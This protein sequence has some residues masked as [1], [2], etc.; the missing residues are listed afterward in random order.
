M[1][2]MFHPP[3]TKCKLKYEQQNPNCE[4]ESDTQVFM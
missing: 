1:P 2:V 4:A 3:K